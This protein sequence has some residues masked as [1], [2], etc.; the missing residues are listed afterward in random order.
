MR[1]GI[2]FSSVLHVALVAL[3]VYGLP[4]SAP[5]RSLGGTPVPVIFENPLKDN[6]T[7]AVTPRSEPVAPTE[8][9]PDATPPLENTTEP[10]QPAAPNEALPDPAAAPAPEGALSETPEGTTVESL[11]QPELPEGASAG[12][13]FS[14][15]P[16][17]V[18][19]PDDEPVE[20]VAP[21]PLVAPETSLALTEKPELLPPREDPAPRVASEDA[22]PV[23]QSAP[24]PLSNSGVQAP[25]TPIA[26]ETP[27]QL[28]QPEA[29][30][31]EE[32]VVQAPSTARP[33][34]EVL[35]PEEIRTPPPA[36]VASVAEPIAAPTPPAP[37]EAAAP[38]PA[39]AVP[40]KKPARDVSLPKEEPPKQ[41]QT[42][43]KPEPESEP[44]QN[45]A[46]PSAAGELIARIAGDGASQQEPE[47]E[48]EPQ[49]NSR[50]RSPSRSPS[51]SRIPLARPLPA[52]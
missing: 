19:I 26:T 14:P 51:H 43:R 32:P 16:Q 6:V 12:A 45:S 3:L 20:E 38:G 34:P 25:P 33:G 23:L 29:E 50:N 49:Q 18:A 39:L 47:P 21:E 30:V 28:R 8:A 35:T 1:N 36:Q 46:S 17:K 7:A 9:P 24:S 4:D 42:E 2:V 15:V 52:S 31:P 11:E 48:S 10:A 40:R 37:Q 22:P 5:E 41:Q 27:E 13:V 44:Q